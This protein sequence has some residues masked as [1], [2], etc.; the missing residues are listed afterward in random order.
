MYKITVFGNSIPIFKSHDR[1]NLTNIFFSKFHL[2]L[3]KDNIFLGDVKINKSEVFLTLQNGDTLKYPKRVFHD[4]FDRD[5]QIIELIYR[6]DLVKAVCIK[7]KKV[8]PKFN[9]YPF[10]VVDAK[11]VRLFSS[12]ENGVFECF[13]DIYYWKK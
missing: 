1:S 12:C 5:V 6:A 9:N 11:I 4:L 10:S 3:W 2:Q 7:T 8:S 13:G